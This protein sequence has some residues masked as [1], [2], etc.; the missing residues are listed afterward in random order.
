MRAIRLCFLS[1]TLLGNS[2]AQRPIVPQSRILAITQKPGAWDTLKLVNTAPTPNDARNFGSAFPIG[3]GRLGAKV[4]G[5]PAAEV[6]PLNDT[7]FWSGPGPEHFEDAKHLEALAATRAA[8]VVP[9][10]VKAD[11]LVRGM[12][13]PNTQFY[14]PLADLHLTFPGHETFGDYS[15]TLDLDTAVATTKY[16]VGGTTYTREMFASYLAQVIVLRLTADKPGALTFS[17]GIT[18]QQHY[19]RAEVAGDEIVVTGRAPVR[20]SGP[21]ASANIE[22]D[23][24]KGMTMETLLHV[25]AK[26]GNVSSGKDAISVTN[27][28]EVVLILSAATSFNGFDHDPATQGKEPDAIARHY[29]AKAV[30]RSYESLLAEHLAD[31]R[32]LFRRLWVS[33]DGETPNKYALA[34]QWARYVLIVSSRP[35]SG[36]PRNEQGIWN[37]DLAPHYSSNFTLNENPEKYY[38][39]AEPANLGETVEPEIDFVNDLATNGSI[40][41]RVDYGAH[42]WVVHHNSDVWAMTTMVQGD[43]CWADWPVGGFWLS[44]ALWERYAFGLDKAELRAKIYPVLK[45]ASEFALD[46]LVP[47]GPAEGV[48]YLVTSPSTSPEN[49][50]IDPK[51]EQRVAVSRGSTMDMA[52][53]RQLFENTIAGSEALGVDPDFRAKLK[54]TLPKLLPFRVGSQGQLQEWAADFKEWEPTH[55][56]ASHLVSASELNQITPAEPDLFA[57]ARISEDLR[58]TGG[59]HPD[60][61]ALWAR[62]L[63]GDKAL[64][65]LGTRFPTMYDSP[66]AGFAELLL[67]S[68]PIQPVPALAQGSSYSGHPYSVP[69]DPRGCIDLLPALPTAWASGEILGLRARGGYE[70]DIRWDNHQLVA[71]T[72]RSRAGFKPLV[73]VEGKPVDLNKD[74]RITFIMLRDA[75]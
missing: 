74:P 71:A 68:Q 23:Q 30:V 25:S 58:K 43:P 41:A 52:L 35:G 21:T 44:Q 6:I 22:W 69:F 54:A 24:H 48:G 56:H 16:T 2:F 66:P 55:R 59:Y 64:A 53:V 70:A 8:L 61:A 11:Q 13:G 29:L 12:E 1:F 17:V 5:W 63:E 10:Y 49:H 7:T 14:E 28:N 75:R 38:A 32:G 3:N 60:K 34:Y 19:G 40:T 73:E 72:I 33:I 46:L 18:T 57:A 26:G 4:F 36:A 9:D 20:I 62:L 15:N 37:H 65:A 51:T 47:S 27:A 45:G 39:T 42:G 50:F 31:Y 67:Q